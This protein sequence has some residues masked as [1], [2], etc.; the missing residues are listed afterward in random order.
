MI[1]AEDGVGVLS[2]TV[3]LDVTEKI[4]TIIPSISLTGTTDHT[5]LLTNIKDEFGQQYATTAVNFT[6]I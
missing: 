4:I 3:T 2:A 5:I 1:I 6:T